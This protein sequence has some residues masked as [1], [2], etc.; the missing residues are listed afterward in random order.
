MTDHRHVLESGRLDETVDVTREG[1]FIGVGQRR[2]RAPDARKIDGGNS[3]L[4]LSEYRPERD[5]DNASSSENC[6]G[7]GPLE[8]VPSN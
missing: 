2:D 3:E 4:P 5:V 7:A 8:T 6:A 1:S